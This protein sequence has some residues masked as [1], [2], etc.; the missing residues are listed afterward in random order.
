[1]AV[2]IYKVEAD[3]NR[4]ISFWDTRERPFSEYFR[5]MCQGMSLKGKWLPAPVEIVDG[6]IG[7]FAGGPVH[8]ANL[9]ISNSALDSV[10]PLI[11]NNC[12]LLPFSFNEMQYH[13]IYIPY[14]LD[15]LDWESS[16]FYFNRKTMADLQE[17]RFLT[18]SIPDEQRFFRLPSRFEY[19]CTLDF[20]EAIEAAELTGLSFRFVW[21]SDG[22]VPKET[23]LR[24]RKKKEAM[25]KSARPRTKRDALL[26]RLWQAIDSFGSEEWLNATLSVKAAE[27]KGA[28]D[29][30]AADTE[31][32]KAAVKHGIAKKDIQRLCRSIAY[33]SVFETLVAIE[34]ECLDR[35]P[36]LKGLHESLLMADPQ[37]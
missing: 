37:K 6:R 15:C 1:M 9:S 29:V 32:L 28:Q 19:Y 4:Y 18:A 27:L 2:T 12:E 26:E 11:N 14:P 17:P 8:F 7:D 10:R 25:F 31:V 20:K 34:E 24:K 3:V 21:S 5:E 13:A 16:S 36:A 22:S 23:V 35:S 33:Q 30:I